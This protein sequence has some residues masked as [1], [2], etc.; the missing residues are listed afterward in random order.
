M[1]ATLGQGD[2]LVV[3]GEIKDGYVNVQVAAAAGWVQI[4]LVQ[5]Q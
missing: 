3:V 4:V 1:L 2:Q 5:K